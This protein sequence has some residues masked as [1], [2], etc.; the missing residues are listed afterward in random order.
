M[1]DTGARRNSTETCVRQ[2]GDVFSESGVPQRRRELEAF[3]HACAHG[4]AAG[5]HHDIAGL[6]AFVLDRC[7]R[8]A[9]CQEHLAGPTLR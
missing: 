9:L 5:E 6:N 2:Q 1:T 3:F 8:F 7:D 4:T